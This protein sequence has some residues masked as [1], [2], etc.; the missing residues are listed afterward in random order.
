MD[1]APRT[2]ADVAKLA[3]NDNCLMLMAIVVYRNNTQYEQRYSMPGSVI[4]NRGFSVSQTNVMRIIHN[5]VQNIPYT[6]PNRNGMR[7]LV[8][9]SMVNPIMLARIRSIIVRH[10]GQIIADSKRTGKTY[11]MPD[12]PKA[13]EESKANYANWLNAQKTK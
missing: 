5:I 8:G 4:D 13:S 7:V 6:K 10:A 11:T 12:A 1:I 9:P 3:S 2:R